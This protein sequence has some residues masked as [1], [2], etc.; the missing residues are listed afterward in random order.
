MQEDLVKDERLLNI[1]EAAR[2][3]N[4]SEIS[5]RRWTDR[6]QLPCVRV[7]AK[8]ERRFRERDL[9]AFLEA[10]PAGRPTPRRG[11]ADGQ[12][13]IEGL[14]VDSGSHLCALYETDLGR[15]K[16]AVPFLTDGLRAGD[17]CVLVADPD[18]GD[19]ILTELRKHRPDVDRDVRERRLIRS[20]GQRTS[21]ALY[22]FLESTFL[23]LTHAG[24]RRIRVV[25]DMAAS[26]A[27][28]MTLEDLLAFEAR[29]DQ[30][31]ADRFPVVSLCQNDARRFPGVGILGALKC[32]RDTFQFPLARFLS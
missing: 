27:L 15:I 2:L 1:K 25:G 10:Q 18:I 21:E 30:F 7:G 16:L 32:H 23:A 12:I 26:L 3:L 14:T 24:V 19:T 17:S 13:F 22:D 8:R 31:L 29:Y 20:E 4:V 6:G 28:G 9:L 11:V 5:L